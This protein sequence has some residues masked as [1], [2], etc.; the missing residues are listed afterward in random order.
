M[1]LSQIKNPEFIKKLTYPELDCLASDIR[2]CI[3][4]TVSK[5]GGHLS[6]NLGCVELTIALHKVFDSPKDKLLFDVG[7]QTYTHKILTG[8]YNGFINTLRCYDGLSGYQK[9]CESEHDIMEAGH[10]STSISIAEGLAIARDLNNEDYHIVSVIGDAS[11]SSGIALEAINHLAE[12]NNKVIIVLNDNEMSISKPVGGISKFLTGVRG[13]SKYQ[14]SKKYFISWSKHKVTKPLY[15]LLK[16]VKNGFKY[17][18]LGKDNVF[19]CMGL[20]YLGPFDGHNIKTIV[21]GLE[22]AK[23]MNSSVIVHVLTQKGKGYEKAENDLDGSWH[24][25]GSFDI[26]SGTVRKNDNGISW[27]SAI[28]NLIDEFNFKNEDTVLLTPAMISGS[29]LKKLFFKYPDRT[30]DVGIS[31]EHAVTMAAGLALGGKKPIISIYSTFMQRAYDNLNHDLARMKLGA[32]IAVD[33]AGLVGEDGETH[34]GIFD[35]AICKSLPN[36]CIS[37]PLD[38]NDA[39]NILNFSYENNILSFVRYPRENL[40]DENIDYKLTKI[41]IGQ[42]D[43]LIKADNDTLVISTGPVTKSLLNLF[44]DDEEIN[45]D[46]LFAR[47]YNPVDEHKL[48]KAFKHYKNIIVYDIYSIKEG[49]FESI[50]EFAILSQYKGKLINLSLPTKFIKHGTIE[51]LLNYLK[52]D[53]N[54]LKTTIKLLK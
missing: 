3:I 48:I 11:I 53:K 25:V 38:Y 5:H 21:K 30:I 29:K 26:E 41:S 6:S 9:R 2:K 39:A 18:T 27:S 4:E 24:G 13:S 40:M 8:R 37:M 42:W 32:I 35:V 47:F 46:L 20:E 52:L 14:K 22:N 45:A 1:D 23:K 34:H 50:A 51:E 49:L 7:H 17:M 33:R 43:Y 15:K 36:S 16:K 54:T 31:E 10:S 28:S 44:K 12:V 19:E